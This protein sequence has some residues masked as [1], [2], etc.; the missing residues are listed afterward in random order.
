[1]ALAVELCLC[2]Y[3][4]IWGKNGLIG[5]FYKRQENAAFEHKITALEDEIVQLEQEIIRWQTND[6]YKE[7]IAREQLQMAR[8]DDEIFYI[9][10]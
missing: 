4:Y 9:G 8:A 2:C 6:F 5:I 3:C 10:F 1:M 7:K